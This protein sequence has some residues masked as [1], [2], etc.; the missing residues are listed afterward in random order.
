MRMK[1]RIYILILILA[2]GLLTKISLDGQL[3]TGFLQSQ[4]QRDSF[5]AEFVNNRAFNAEFII[6]PE[7]ETNEASNIKKQKSVVEN[8]L[9]GPQTDNDI[10]KFFEII[11]YY[12]TKTVD[13]EIEEPVRDPESNEII[14]LPADENGIIEPQTE[15]V[16][17]TQRLLNTNLELDTLEQ[18]AG[19]VVYEDI[20]KLG[21]IVNQALTSASCNTQVAF[22]FEN[23]KEDVMF[24]VNFQDLPAITSSQNIFIHDKNSLAPQQADEG[25]APAP[26][27]QVLT[28]RSELGK[29]INLFQPSL[30]SLLIQTNQKR[31]K[32][33]AILL[34]TTDS[35]V[36]TDNIN[37]LERHLFESFTSTQA[38]SSL[39]DGKFT[40]VHK[41]PQ[42]PVSGFQKHE[43]DLSTLD[44]INLDYN[45]DYIL[46]LKVESNMRASETNFPS[47]AELNK[48]NREKIILIH[49]QDKLRNLS[50][51]YDAIPNQ[52]QNIKASSDGS[53]LI[54]VG[55]PDGLRE[56]LPESI[57]DNLEL[58]ALELSN[59]NDDE[60][61][62]IFATAVTQQSIIFEA[63]DTTA[64]LKNGAYTAK[65]VIFE[66]QEVPLNYTYILEDIENQASSETGSD[67]IVDRNIVTLL[68]PNN[69]SINITGRNLSENPNRY[70]LT[71]GNLKKDIARSIT[72]NDEKT[73][74]V[75]EFGD[76][77]VCYSKQCSA[78][79][80]GLF[81]TEGQIENI[82]NLILE[83][84]P[85]EVI[86]SGTNS[87]TITAKVA[88]L[89]KYDEYILLINS[90]AGKQEQELFAVCTD[91]EN[92]PY[93]EYEFENEL[94]PGVYEFG[95]K[96]VDSDFNQH[97]TTRKVIKE[98]K[99][100]TKDILKE[101]T[102]ICTN[103]NKSLPGTKTECKTL[104]GSDEII[105]DE[106]LIFIEG[107]EVAQAR[108]LK[109]TTT[110]RGTFLSAKGIVV[111]DDK[112]GQPNILLADRNNTED[113]Y[114]TSS[115][116]DIIDVADRDLDGFSSSDK[117]HVE[118]TE[119]FA[120]GDNINFNIEIPNSLEFGFLQVAY[121]G[122]NETQKNKGAL[123]TYCSREFVENVNKQFVKK[124]C[125]KFT[126]DANISGP[127]V[128]MIEDYNTNKVK[129][130]GF[131]DL[132]ITGFTL[133][134]DNTI[135]KFVERQK[136]AFRATAKIYLINSSMGVNYPHNQ[137]QSNPGFLGR[138][139][140][141]QEESEVAPNPK[142]MS[143][144]SDINITNPL[145]NDLVYL[146]DLGV[147]KGQFEGDT[148]VANT[149][150]Q[151]L[152]AHL[153][154]LV[155][156]LYS[157]TEN[158][159]SVQPDV[160]R[161]LEE[162]ADID[163]D[164]IRNQ[165]NRWWV[166]PTITLKH[167]NIIRTDS[168]G[169]LQPFK[170][171]TQYEAASIIGDASNMLPDIL[172]E[173][174]VKEVVEY[175]ESIDIKIN[176]EAPATIGDL[177]ALIA[178]AIKVRKNP[179]L[180]Q[181]A[182]KSDINRIYNQSPQQNYN[183][184]PYQPTYQPQEINPYYQNNYYNQSISPYRN[185]YPSYG[186]M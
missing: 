78:L 67:I 31:Y 7:N 157:K 45:K 116:I 105:E 148:V 146:N 97:S 42:R 117:L 186:Y 121:I 24:T 79:R 166:V 158:L 124:A 51:A 135:T 184:N 150:K 65:L 178:R 56:T 129:V 140:G 12:N 96:T 139:F 58:V 6:C 82:T 57:E 145:C 87:N 156:R 100:I 179:Y 21:L 75:L 9:S 163:E 92:G 183:P 152:R 161:F 53:L 52:S 49:I 123:F 177:V 64:N 160:R 10:N 61:I 41:T 143:L 44:N 16:T 84:E 155:E 25:A 66:D 43:L 48:Q 141:A 50:Q 181:Q 54:T 88:C 127:D 80:L 91:S 125:D 138:L 176:P 83:I 159:K 142:C 102:F 95:V 118:I 89:D 165:S 180:Y 37:A 107:T 182:P 109:K 169:N 114:Q 134:A 85:R 175:Y 77:D 2:A 122:D 40:G 23:N 71:L 111:P 90:D 19:F 28:E 99:N 55:I 185:Y 59:G 154:T 8:L 38:G 33:Q 22:N 63:N 167:Y 69:V 14:L 18:G 136:D 5:T 103:G 128:I 13:V 34:E 29:L 106:M 35:E 98:N 15:K 3:L 70:A 72:V 73:E 132:R 110:N 47:E 62:L 144:Y 17:V 126:K 120:V 108:R 115:F 171:V 130:P 36:N 113:I 11:N 147:Y 149:H 94:P 74:A 168:N 153:F 170:P 164:T 137:T 162:V 119:D 76:L 86:I 174:R 151:A 68:S 93:L 1:K 26:A 20:Q 27:N 81:D 39:I 60:N 30:S 32:Y 133:N 101:K 4:Q 46:A 112:G 172:G 104:I 173:D 131:Y